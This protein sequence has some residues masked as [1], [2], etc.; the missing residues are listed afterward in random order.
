MTTTRVLSCD[1]PYNN[2]GLGKIFAQTVE[3][4]RSKGELRCYYTSRKK[5]NDHKGHEI[6]LER[7]RR[8]FNI[9]PLRNSLGWRDFLSASL[10]DRAVARVL[11]PAEAFQGFS[12]RAKHSFVRARQLKYKYIYLESPTC[13][14]SH[15]MRQHHKAIVASPIERSWLT[16]MQYKTT[17]CEYEMTDFIYVMSEYAR[18]TYI[19]QGVPES[20]LRR[21]IITTDPR[22]APPIGNFGFRG[23]SV[24]YIGR[25]HVSK[26]L[27]VLIE[28]FARIKDKDAELIL[29]GGYGTDGMEKYLQ[30]KLACDHRI[31]IRPGDPLPYLHRADVLVHPSFEDGL[32]LAPLEAL[33]CGVPVVVTDDTGMK[34]YV[35]NGRNGYILPTGDVDALVEHL[36]IIRLRPLKGTFEPFSPSAKEPND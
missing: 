10:F 32:A 7:F 18:Q 20:K 13:H 11:S 24:V 4:A 33:A 8:V 5:P 17:L 21:R 16:K 1:A 19:E 2:G 15:V 3:T 22:F 34:E 36:R 14:V 6:C 23:F 31:K 30:M 27:A 29:I 35:V 12:G 26:G 9:P 25:L 28:A